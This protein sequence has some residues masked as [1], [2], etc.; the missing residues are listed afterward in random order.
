MANKGDEKTNTVT[1]PSDC[2]FA[3][4]DTDY[5]YTYDTAISTTVQQ[6]LLCSVLDS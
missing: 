5:T 4:R 3:S 6:F 2:G 1:S